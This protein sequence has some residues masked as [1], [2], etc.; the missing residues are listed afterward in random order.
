VL[1][2]KTPLPKE[3]ICVGIDV[4]KAKFDVQVDNAK[5]TVYGSQHALGTGQIDQADLALVSR[6]DRRGI[7]RRLRTG[8]AV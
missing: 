6:I 5:K 3:A 8:A 1:Q 7:Q 2:L 4:A